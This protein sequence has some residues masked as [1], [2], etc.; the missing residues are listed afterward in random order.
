MKVI[1]TSCG[2]KTEEI[3]SAFL[4]MLPYESERV[5]ALFIPTAAINPDSFG[6]LPKRMNDLLKCGIKSENIVV[7]DLHRNMTIEELSGYDVVYFCGGDPR[8]LLERVNDSGFSKALK[9]YIN[10]D[11]IVLGVSAGSM[12][13]AAN[14]EN[15]L[16]LVNT[17]LYVHSENGW[18]AGS[19]TYPFEKGI[20]L[21]DN[22]ALIMRS[23]EDIRIVGE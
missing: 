17:D 12:I 20:A 15:N 10:Q 8:Y 5:H 16:G 13:F 4:S 14:M 23:F 2:L 18:P 1:L 21:T 6:V 7:F 3:K 19:I 11:G 9:E 22:Q